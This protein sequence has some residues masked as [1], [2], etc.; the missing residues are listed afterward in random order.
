MARWT[1]P[2]AAFV[3]GIGASIGCAVSDPPELAPAFDPSLP[4]VDAGIYSSPVMGGD[5][6][7]AGAKEGRADPDSGPPVPKP[8]QGEVLVTEVMYNPLGSEPKAEWFEVRSMA[9]AP[10]DLG[11]LTIVD[12]A[13]RTHVIAPRTIVTP[14]DYLLFVRDKATAL[15]Q[16]VPAAAIVYEYGT[17]QLDSAGVILLN[18]ATGSVTLTDGAKTIAQAPYG[19]WFMQSGGSS[20]QLHALAFAESASQASWCLSAN[21]WTTGSDKGTPGAASDCP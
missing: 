21:A 16:H 12:G 4:G 11:G 14:G 15:A 13:G 17:G 1:S 5:A 20:V 9:N 18:G 7:D 19:P 8:T 10:R 2:V 6:T 3:A